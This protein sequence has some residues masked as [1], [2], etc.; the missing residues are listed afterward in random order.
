MTM[1]QIT[2]EKLAQE[3]IK[4]RNDIPIII[5][6]GFSEKVTTENAKMIGIK[7]YAMKPL[8][9]QDLA[10]TIRKALNK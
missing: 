4:I 8:L 9:M 5:C 2:G 6:T 1:P 7:E 3:L 10:K